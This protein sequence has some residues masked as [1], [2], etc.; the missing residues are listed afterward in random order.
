[1]C[2][3]GTQHLPKLLGQQCSELLRPRKQRCANGCNNF[4]RCW[5][6]TRVGLPREVIALLSLRA[7]QTDATLLSYALWWSRRED[8]LAQK[9]DRFQILR[10]NSNNTQQGVHTDVTCNIQQCWELLANNVASVSM[11]LYAI[12]YYQ[13]LTWQV[14]D[15]FGLTTAMLTTWSN[16]SI[17]VHQSNPVKND[18]EGAIKSVSINEASILSGLNLKKM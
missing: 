13:A 11:G 14:W 17:T 1:M 16:T 5:L 10:N 3:H 15:A 2:K 6:I 4:Q 8:F 9:F 7:V 18:S 12:L